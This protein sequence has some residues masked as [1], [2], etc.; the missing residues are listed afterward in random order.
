VE[1]GQTEKEESWLVED[2]VELNENMK[3]SLLLFGYIF[4]S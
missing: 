1:R 2:T 3:T 4:P